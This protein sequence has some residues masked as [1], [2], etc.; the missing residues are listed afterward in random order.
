MKILWACGLDDNALGRQEW[1]EA[2]AAR[3]RARIPSLEVMLLGAVDGGLEA[4]TEKVRGAD[5]TV[6]DFCTEDSPLNLDVVVAATLARYCC[7]KPVYILIH[8]STELPFDWVRHG[9]LQI[10]GKGMGARSDLQGWFRRLILEIE[11]EQPQSLGGR[12]ETNPPEVFVAM[13]FQGYNPR[14][15]P[16]PGAFD[17]S[18]FLKAVED[19][20]G[21]IPTRGSIPTSPKP[22]VTVVGRNAVGGDVVDNITKRLATASVV[23]VDFSPDHR[24]GSGPNANVMTEATIA[25]AGFHHDKTIILCAQQGTKIPRSWS[26]FSTVYY[27][28]ATMTCTDDGTTLVARLAERIG[29]ALGIDPPDKTTGLR[30]PD[31]FEQAG[32]TFVR[33]PAGP[34]RRGWSEERL[35]RLLQA[36]GLPRNAVEHNLEQEPLVTWPIRGFAISRDPISCEQFRR[37][38]S[39]SGYERLAGRRWML[40]GRERYPITEVSWEDAQAY[41][42][43]YGFRLPTI[44]EWEYAATGGDDRVYPWGDSFDNGIPN[45]HATGVGLRETGTAPGNLSRFDLRDM[46]GNAWELLDAG[47]ERRRQ[48]DGRVVEAVSKIALGGSFSDDGVQSSSFLLSRYLLAPDARKDEVGFRVCTRE[49]P[50]LPPGLQFVRIPGGTLEA[51]CTPAT[52]AILARLL[53]PEQAASVAA[54][55]PPRTVRVAPFALTKDPV[56]NCDYYQ[57]TM[58]TRHRQPKHWWPTPRRSNAAAEEYP[59]P[60]WMRDLPVTHVSL[61]DALAYAKWIDATLPS[62]DE[63]E[64]AARGPE[65]SM[66]PWGSDFAPWRCNTAE[67]RLGRPNAPGEFPDSVGRI[68]LRDLCGNVSEIVR[69]QRADV[70][71]LR[72]GSWTHSCEILGASCWP[73]YVERDLSSQWNGFRVA[74]R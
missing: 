62:G 16:H 51:G 73:A 19:S 26:T 69:G 31:T 11:P 71:E 60:L 2:A 57:F 38:L 8:D 34:Y 54:Q 35:Q 68:A 40:G 15:L 3:V 7:C 63:W 23:V 17:F 53:R 58:A 67:A 42:D 74:R 14:N 36:T 44:V 27:D 13:P 29:S 5:V 10:L 33:I 4:V 49:P 50:S 12:I 72:G 65:G 24:S 25:R 32:V 28:P 9:Q 46:A 30:G 61:D 39:E 70:V 45:N 48:E 22:I 52:Q 41:C 18:R 64:W 43:F 6:V 59:F 47:M 21:S 20:V 56:S 37:F 55:L 66:Y 1:M